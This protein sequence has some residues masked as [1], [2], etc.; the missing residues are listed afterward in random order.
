M[1]YGGKTPISINFNNVDF[2]PDLSI[3]EFIKQYPDKCFIISVGSCVSFLNNGNYTTALI[4]KG[5]RKVFRKTNIL[6]NSANQCI[7]NGI[8][9]AVSAIKLPT[10][11]L[12][13]TSTSLGFNS[14]K[15]KNYQLCND[16][17]VT[18]AEKE[19]NISISVCRGKGEE[20]YRFVNAL[21]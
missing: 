9:E 6:I 8:M 16:I 2:P 12:I 10:D 14:P 17:M 7:L 5:R 20:L 13:L 3:S 21:G 11:I 15:S 1:K 18:L 19:C 4:Y